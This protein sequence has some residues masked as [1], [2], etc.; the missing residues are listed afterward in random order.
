MNFGF[1][2]QLCN[3]ASCVPPLFIQ[4][5]VNAISELARLPEGL[6]AEID[7]RTSSVSPGQIHLAHDPWQPGDALEAW[8]QQWASAPRGPLVLNTK[9]DG[10]EEEDMRCLARHGCKNYFFLDTSLPTLVR[11][12]RAG[13]GRHLALRASAMEPL[14]G[15]AV[16]LALPAEQRPNTL[17]VD[18]FDARPMPAGSLS[19]LADRIALCLVSP[20]LQGDLELASLDQFLAL[21]RLANMVCTKRPQVW[22]QSLARNG[23]S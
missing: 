22:K 14:A 3:G 5:R 13:L 23:N 18:C 12:S 2:K 8:V 20:D 9:E 16:W 1:F 4:H 11:L 7:L 21:G 19:T 17:W 6:G 15:L 10:L